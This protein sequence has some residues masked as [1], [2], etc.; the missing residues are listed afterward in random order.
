MKRKIVAVEFN[1]FEYVMTKEEM[2]FFDLTIKSIKVLNCHGTVED[3]PD[4]FDVKSFIA[5]IVVEDEEKTLRGTLFGKE[6]PI[7]FFFEMAA[8][9][10]VNGEKVSDNKFNEFVNSNYNSGGFLD[11]LFS[12]MIDD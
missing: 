5:D 10:N 7:D 4:E 9:F 6:D 12:N 3:T 1:D 2:R 11:V 8:V